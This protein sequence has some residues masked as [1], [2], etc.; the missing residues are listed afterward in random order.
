MFLPMLSKAEQER[1]CKI[2]ID[3][4]KGLYYDGNNWAMMNDA[5]SR[6]L[7]RWQIQIDMLGSVALASIFVVLTATGFWAAV[8]WD[9]HRKNSS[10]DATARSAKLD[11]AKGWCRGGLIVGVLC[12]YG[13]VIAYKDYTNRAIGMYLSYMAHQ[14]AKL[15]RVDCDRLEE[16]LDPKPNWFKLPVACKVSKELVKESA[17]AH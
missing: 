15:A 12:T 6:V 16:F 17:D 2:A 10:Q 4:A 3:V 7:R 14:D 8:R 13:Y 5:S 1:R 9:Q 11:S